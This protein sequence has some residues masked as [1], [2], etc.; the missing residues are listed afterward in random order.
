M[1]NSQQEWSPETA[2]YWNARPRNDGAAL[3]LRHSLNE[4]AKLVG[5]VQARSLCFA[6][7]TRLAAE[8]PLSNVEKLGDIEGAARRFLQTHDLGW[9]RLDESEDALDFVH[10]CAPFQSWFGEDAAAWS[11]ALLEG[12]YAEWLRQLGASPLLELRQIE[13]GPDVG[14]VLV[15][16]F[17]HEARFSGR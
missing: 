7:G 15:Y 1:L 3:V 11:G 6:I 9:L 14:D 5:P 16:R 8:H 10:G 12:L 17:S 13:P 4:V 2:A